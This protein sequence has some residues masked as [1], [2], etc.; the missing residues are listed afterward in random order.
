[1]PVNHM[2]AFFTALVCLSA[3]GCATTARCDSAGAPD[4][5]PPLV[6]TA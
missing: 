4:A 1:M 5:L 6:A 2:L 3:V